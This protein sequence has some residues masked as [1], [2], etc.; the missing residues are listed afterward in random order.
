MLLLELGRRGIDMSMNDRFR[1]SYCK[2]RRAA[3]RRHS[4]LF[5]ILVKIH[6]GRNID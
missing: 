4:L 3:N 2:D 5:V 6:T 1:I